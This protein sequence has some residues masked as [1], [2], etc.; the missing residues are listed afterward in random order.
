MKTIKDLFRSIKE[1]FTGK[2]QDLSIT[3][4]AE[5]VAEKD[6]DKIDVEL[7]ENNITR[8]RNGISQFVTNHFGPDTDPDEDVTPKIEKV[9]RD[10]INSLIAVTNKWIEESANILDNYRKQ[11]LAQMTQWTTPDGIANRYRSEV[12]KYEQLAREALKVVFESRERKLHEAGRLRQERIQIHNELRT[13][14]IRLL[15]DEKA[16]LH[17]INPLAYILGVVVFF[18]IIA[19]LEAM[20]GMPIFRF[21]SSGNFAYWLSMAFALSLGGFTLLSSHHQNKVSA[22][23]KALRIYEYTYDKKNL[24]KSGHPDNRVIKPVPVDAKDLFI[25]R[26]GTLGLCLIAF[27]LLGWRLVT[28][29]GM[30]EGDGGISFVSAGL[31]LAVTALMYFLDLIFGPNFSFSSYNQYNRLKE[32]QKEIQT[33]IRNLQN[34]NPD[35]A[36]VQRT[37]N[38]YKGKVAETE[39]Q[40]QTEAE[41]L[42]GECT[43]FCEQSSLLEQVVGTT[44]HQRR[45][46]FETINS[47]LQAEPYEVGAITLKQVLGQDKWKEELD[48][49]IHKVSIPDDVLK[50]FQEFQ[51]TY[52]LP[53][54]VMITN[55]KD[56]VESVEAEA[57]ENV[58]R[59]EENAAQ[60]KGTV[61]E[62][63]GLTS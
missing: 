51:P 6:P 10:T 21:E 54:D 5:A 56:L 62:P 42:P 50:K 58:R 57:K 28:S 48:T 46:D 63:L 53:Q 45:L 30:Q 32:R 23:K 9:A 40:I 22:A 52:Q 11:I 19:T 26:A 47:T 13:M 37:L 33:Q 2:P 1:F 61:I 49:R 7:F 18:G 38:W 60:K 8:H 29:L 20:L 35:T 55:F 34:Q 4:Q 36:S 3:D 24:P 15:G 31:L 14:R 16:E 27:S 17:S 41:W 43:K 25:A 39:A 44:Q 59:Q 12:Q